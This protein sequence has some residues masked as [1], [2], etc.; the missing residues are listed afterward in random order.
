MSDQATKLAGTCE[1]HCSRR[2]YL[3]EE[4]IRAERER[5][6]ART[7]L[8]NVTAIASALRHNL[9]LAAA[10]LD[11]SAAARIKNCQQILDRLCAILAPEGDR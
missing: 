3:A 11:L 10:T 7:A 5:D 4:L 9:G 8:G 1:A 6:E 2:H